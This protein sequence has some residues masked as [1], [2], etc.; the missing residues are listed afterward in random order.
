MERRDSCEYYRKHVVYMS[1]GEG[2]LHIFGE[3]SY[4]SASDGTQ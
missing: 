3:I 2:Y 1:N 4:Y